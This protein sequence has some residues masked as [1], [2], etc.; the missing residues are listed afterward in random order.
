MGRNSNG[1]N[2]PEHL[3]EEDRV[4]IRKPETMIIRPALPSKKVTVEEEVDV[5][6][7]EEEDERVLV[8]NHRENETA[9]PEED[10][11]S[12]REDSAFVHKFKPWQQSVAQN[13]LGAPLS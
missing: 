12:G 9:S 11:D 13:V 4:D 7:D 3:S 10:E 8:I 2:D 6:I 5:D 1:E